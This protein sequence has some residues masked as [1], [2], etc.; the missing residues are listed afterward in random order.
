MR[1]SSHTPIYIF[2]KIYFVLHKNK[3]HTPYITHYAQQ[4]IDYM[5]CVMY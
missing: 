2:C 5:W 1:S 4:I 3:I